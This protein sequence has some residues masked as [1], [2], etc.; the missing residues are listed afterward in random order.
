MVLAQNPADHYSI[1]ATLT[2]GKQS[3]C[4]IFIRSVLN[5]SPA[6]RAGI[7][8]GDILVAV[9]GAAIHTIGDAAQ[10]ISQTPENVL[11]NVRRGNDTLTV[12][13]TS[14]RL[15]DILRGDGFRMLDDGQIV[16]L[17]ATEDEIAQMM[18]NPDR[19][20][21]RVFQQTHYPA[22]FDLYYPGFEAFM[23]KDPQQV[24][25]GGIETGPASDAGLRY[26]DIIVS[27]NGLS[28]G[29]KSSSEIEAM[30]SSV[31]ARSIAL[32]I[33]R[34]GQK[35]Q[36]SFPLQRASVVLQRNAKKLANG[37][38]IPV[39]ASDAYESCFM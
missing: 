24:V 4:P 11:L 36:I 27:V 8:P 39:W 1:G 17:D 29:G 20:V 23:L 21:G 18:F 2:K 3:S 14:A 19:I 30:L 10:R 31:G 32:L 33:D 34:T 38:I 7:R 22:N 25:V 9:N 12:T 26:G 28:V 37:K 5:N 35:R 15:G 6:A 16:A 13:V